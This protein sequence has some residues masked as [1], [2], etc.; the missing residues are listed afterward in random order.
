MKGNYLML[1]ITTL[2]VG[3]SGIV[4]ILHNIFGLFRSYLVFMGIPSLTGSTRIIFIVLTT[5]TLILLIA[6]WV[7][8]RKNAEHPKLRLFLT[9][10]L[11]HASMLIIAAGNGL[12]EYHFS[13]FM[14][15]A[16]IT[17][18][19]SIALIMTS[20]LIFAA[21]HFVGYFMYPELLCGTSDYRF[22]LL[23]IHAVFLLLTSGAN[24]TL[25]LFNLQRQ[26]A[27]K[28]VQKEANA[29]F[30]LI[31][32]NLTQTITDLTKVSGSVEHGL[33]ESRLASNDIAKSTLQLQEG[34]ENQ[35]NLAEDNLLH[36]QFVADTV[37]SLEISTTDVLQQAIRATELADEGEQLID[38]TTVQFESAHERS[39]SLD[40]SIKNLYQSIQDVGQFATEITD[41]ANQTN[42]LSL[43]A[44]IEA[45]RAGEAGKGFSVVAEEVRKLAH[46][47]E[48]SASNVN[49]IVTEIITSATQVAD[50]IMANVEEI[51]SG[52]HQLQKTNTAFTQ[53][54]NIT[55]I[56]E[57]KM[58]VVYASVGEVNQKKNQLST[59]MVQLKANANHELFSSQEISAAA[60]EQFVSIDNLNRSVEHL[61]IS[62][63]NVEELVLQI[64]G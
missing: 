7:L 8:Y 62:T 48:K 32:A 3:L 21:H 51:Q 33:S 5:I 55:T 47:S 29:R 59:S 23:M 43:N 9:L 46:Q 35:L 37:A 63:K 14:V 4:Y 49:F 36:L 18:F 39:L 54:Q 19:N 45:V 57:D 41:I 28:K 24:I 11:T 30:Q 16:F 34:A 61:Q 42:L 26:E 2:V 12:V 53:I 15:L 17:Y 13:I 40:Q 27:A 64:K 6:S 52:M 60:E 58:K 50:E 1:W 20:T 10:T 31:I 38:A 56:V 44:S 25:T 22:S